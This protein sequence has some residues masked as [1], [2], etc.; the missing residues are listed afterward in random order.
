M[1]SYRIED[2][3]DGDWQPDAWWTTTNYG[4][5]APGVLTPVSRQLW[6]IG[7]E[8]AMRRAFYDMG[9]LTR[10]E[11]RLPS[12]DRDRLVGVF[13]G[14]LTAKLNWQLEVID[15]MPGADGVAVAEQVFGEL[16]ADLDVRATRDR[17]LYATARLPV[18]R[19]IAPRRM[20]AERVAVDAWWRA[21]TTRASG[22]GL[23]EARA[24]WQAASDAFVDT[25]TL[26]CIVAW[27]VV[28]PAS[29]RLAQLAAAAGDPSL[30]GRLVAGLGSH[31]ELDVVSDLWRV[32]RG[33][34]SMHDFL[35]AHGYHGTKAGELANPTWREDPAP[36]QSLLEHYRAVAEDESPL[37]V[38][39]ARA[40]ERAQA[41]GELLRALPARQ[42]RRAQLTLRRAGRS[43]PLRG[44][45][46]VA[47]LQRLDV[48][49]CA[50]RRIGELLAHAGALERPEDAFFLT[51]GELLDPGN[52][53]WQTAVRE[54]RQRRA[55]LE[56]QTMPA[57]WRGRPT[58]EPA[59][60]PSGAE[61][62]E[63]PGTVIVT[64]IGASGGVVE[65]T[66]RVVHEPYVDDL[67]PGH[68]LVAPLTD[69]AWAPVMFVAAALVVD[70]GGPISHAAVVARELGIPCVMGTGDGTRRLHTGD[71]V[72]VDGQTG[73][74]E[75]LAPAPTLS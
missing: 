21:E 37:A 1:T 7:G 23:P 66:V 5:A 56:T 14:R 35:A 22:L 53:P 42:R 72:R 34:L 28:A 48:V 75:V 33:G 12:S 52:G 74:V 11:R 59:P 70:V 18:Q 17:R 16:P 73:V 51:R 29:E 40:D 19:L 25:M 38:V 63:T 26:H 9:A 3:Y 62:L 49:R 58:L 39:R 36:V 31:E 57:L 61:D 71:R 13:A 30:A 68:I 64:G 65:G 54:R 41:A 67:E 32:S 10:E 60:S 55:E 27:A 24:Q 46:K 8:E 6:A 4:E 20:R 50:T 47:F 45:G 2:I 44:V 69:P 43:V 15:R